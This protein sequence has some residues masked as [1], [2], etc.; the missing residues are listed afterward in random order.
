[1]RSKLFSK[2]YFK[3]C[4]FDTALIEAPYLP[5]RISQRINFINT[6]PSFENTKTIYFPFIIIQAWNK[7]YRMPTAAPTKVKIAE[8]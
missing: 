7:E 8:V 5:R 2:N 6:M 1:M 3:N 4:P